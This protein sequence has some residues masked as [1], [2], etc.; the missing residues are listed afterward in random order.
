VI[1]LF[2]NDIVVRVVHMNIKLNG[3]YLFF[4]VID[5]SYNIVKT[6]VLRQF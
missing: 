3:L 6:P 1:Q 2:T 5:P 4:L